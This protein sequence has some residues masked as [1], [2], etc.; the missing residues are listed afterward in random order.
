MLVRPPDAEVPVFFRGY[1][2]EVPQEGTLIEVL[3]GQLAS[4]PALLRRFPEAKT[5]T[6]YAPG[7]WSLKQSIEH[8]NDAERIFTYRL[9]RIARGDQTPLPG[10]EQDDYVANS[11]ANARPWS[12]LIAEFE[13]VRRS[14]LALVRALPDAAW[15]RTGTASGASSSA[16]MFA[17]VIAG[18]VAHH[19]SL[20]ESKYAP[21]LK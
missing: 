20:I 14:T 8:V 12:E 18:H 11:Q 7:K 3:A 19:A 6:G 9:L 21:L 17:Y 16:R 1:V 4:F 15:V 2:N 13:A 5:E 10:F